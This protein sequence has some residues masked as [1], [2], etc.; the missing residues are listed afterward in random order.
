MSHTNKGTLSK[1]PTS[2]VQSLKTLKNPPCPAEEEPEEVK[3]TFEEASAELEALIGLKSVKEQ[4]QELASYLQFLK[5]RKEKGLTDS[6]IQNIEDNYIADSILPDISSTEI[7]NRVTNNQDL[8]EL[9][10]PNIVRELVVS[11]KLK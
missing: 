6:E 4:I 11:K 1:T 9:A 10:I 5:I 2:R 3:P 8:S 7:R